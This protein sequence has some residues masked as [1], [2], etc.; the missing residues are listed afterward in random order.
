MHD[1]RLNVYNLP[2]DVAESEL[3]GSVVVVIDLLRATSTISQALAS[4][5]RE[6]APFLEVDET[7]AAAELAGRSEVVLGGEREGGRIPGFDVGNSPSEYP[8][9]VVSGRRVFFTTTN[10]TRALY[11]ARRARRVLVGAFLNLSAV[12]ASVQDERCVNILCAGT[13]GMATREDILVA[14]AMVCRLEELWEGISVCNDAAAAARRE[15]GKLVENA[16][17]FARPL[18]EQLAIE[19]RDT[20]G[21]RNLL[22]IGLARDLV[23]C[24]QIDRLNIVPSLDAPNWRITALPVE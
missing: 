9:S 3:A 15:W 16:K 19:L 11:H 23:D 13:G 6:V 12:A 14:G 10:G 22:G 7:L 18:N 17:S 4:G 20:Q 8:S 24:A 21:G 2:R 5:A 1:H